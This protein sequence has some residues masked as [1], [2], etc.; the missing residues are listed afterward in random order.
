MD[1]PNE[2]REVVLEN[3]I[4]RLVETGIYSV[5][6]DLVS[7]H[8]YDRRATVYDLVVSTRSYNSV[9]WGSSP[10]DYSAFARQA[11]TSCPSGRF[12]DAACGSMLFTAPT[13]LDGNRQII[14]FD[15]SLA[16]LRRA[17]KRLTNL[18]GKVPVHILLLQADL[19]DLPFR[20]NSFHTV[21][22]MNVLHH[23]EHAAA[24]IPNLKGLLTDDGQ[25]F[26]TSLVSNNRFIGDSYLKTL[27]AMG[28]FVRPRSNLELKEI[29]DSSLGQAVS[30]QVKG[31]MA[32]I[33]TA[34]SS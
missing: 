9:M 20:P 17:R 10:L 16:M 3:R 21:L 7:Q 11:V 29:L 22:C 4:V 33:T 28:E 8:H 24:L 25:L 2:L 27:Y 23:F 5:L 13:Y 32:F 26:L 12:L 30:Y 31:N 15:Q 19:S 18:S 14:A 34:M 6:P 1:A